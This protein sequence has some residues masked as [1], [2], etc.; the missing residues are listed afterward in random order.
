M[1]KSI[2]R[3]RE[4]ERFQSMDVDPI[5]MF[6][7]ID[8]TCYY[9]TKNRKKERKKKKE[10]KRTCAEITRCLIFVWNGEFFVSTA[11]DM[12]HRLWYR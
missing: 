12:N 8:T 11:T 6:F 4:R 2:R 9:I 10:K 7:V 3:K 1:N 5:A